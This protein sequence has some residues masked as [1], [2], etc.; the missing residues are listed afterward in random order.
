MNVAHFLA[1]GH[2]LSSDAGPLYVQLRKRLLE[3][4]DQQV[5]PPGSP[6]PP[7][8]EI[9]Q[10]TEMSRVTVRKAIRALADEGVIVQKQGSGSF[11]AHRTQPL[12]QP[13]SRLTS[14]SEDMARRG[15]A[16]TSV[17]LERGVFM[18][19][20][21]EVIALAL[22]TEASVTRITRLRSADN[23]PMAIE[24][25]ALPTE[26]LPDPMAVET[27]LYE[28]LGRRGMRPVRAIQKLSA[29]NVN[30]ADAERLEVASGT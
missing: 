21:E 10:I 14:F 15:L 28:A 5:L 13:L 20:P 9:A 30:G 19:S 29:I 7:E 16:S 3:G 6:L 27:S 26:V 4:V 17:W 18:P 11:V 12:E 2:W 24:R 1:P 8:R 22:S 23:Q 25:A